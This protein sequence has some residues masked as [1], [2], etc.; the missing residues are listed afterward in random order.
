MS[1]AET[2]RVVCNPFAH[3]D[4]L[5]RPAGACPCDPVG[6]TPD[7]RW[8]GAR[9]HERTTLTEKLSREDA[10]VRSAAQNTEFDFTPDVQ[11]IPKTPYYLDRLRDGE[12]LAADA[13]TARAAG[14]PFVEPSTALAIAKTTAIASWAAHYGSEPAPTVAFWRGDS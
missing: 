13:M 6:H 11:T 14:L 1:D 7:R 10:S 4:H 8:V 5:G 12:L 9:I 2:L 3:L